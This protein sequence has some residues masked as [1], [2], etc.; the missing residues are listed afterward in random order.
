MKVMISSAGA[1]PA[2]SLI[3][4]FNSRNID[5]VSTD[6]NEN[7]AGLH[8]SKGYLVPKFSEINFTDKII[9]IAKKENVDL[10][11]PILDIE[12]R[13]FHEIKFR[14]DI[15]VAL[16]SLGSI[17]VC[18][19]KKQSLKVCDIGEIKYPKEIDPRSYRGKFIGRPSSGTGSRG[20]IIRSEPIDGDIPDNYV[21]QEF[22]EGQEYSVD[23]YGFSMI[24]PRKR[25]LVKDGQT[26]VGQ[27]DNDPEIIDFASRCAKAFRMSDVSCLQL[28]KSNSGLYF[29]ELNPRYGTGVSLGISAGMDFPMAQLNHYCGLNYK[30]Q[31]ELKH[32]LKM[33]RYYKEI[34]C[35]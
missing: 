17:N 14:S 1:G 31:N 21:W 33:I 23:M 2:I 6:I 9:N 32:G 22:I 10:I 29:I 35:E 27:I 7:A 18:L 24:A 15:P 26:V 12:L 8:L 13:K 25:I 16:N 4:Y 5:V 11:I 20:I 3:K 19:D 28:I 34:Y 30:M